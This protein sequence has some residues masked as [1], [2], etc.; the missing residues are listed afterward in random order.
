MYTLRSDI[1][2]YA[3]LASMHDNCRTVAAMPNAGYKNTAVVHP[4]V[5][6]TH[7]Q[8]AFHW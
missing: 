6:Y 1:H 7:I 5:S 2:V 8:P 3:V 4:G